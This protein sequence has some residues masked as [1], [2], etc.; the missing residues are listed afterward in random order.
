MCLK[1][2]IHETKLHWEE[3]V[4]SE[5]EKSVSKSISTILEMILINSKPIST[6]AFLTNH[7][8]FCIQGMKISTSKKIS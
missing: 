6:I 7:C 8:N 4:E 2:I 5:I 3:N 1:K